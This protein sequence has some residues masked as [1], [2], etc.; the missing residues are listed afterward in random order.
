VDSTGTGA[1]DAATAHL[2][3]TLADDL[4]DLVSRGALRPGDRLPSVR[5]LSKQRRVS[6]STV[7]QA[8]LVLE[9]R[10]LVEARP[11][12]GHYVRAPRRPPPPE[13]RVARQSTSVTRVTVSDLVTRV[14]RAARDPQVVPLGA[15]I[16]SPELYPTDKLHRTLAAVAR[17]A[18]GMG[19]AYD[20][21]P[22]YLP[23]RRH[24]ARRAADAG[25]GLSP[26]DIV[27]TAG[28]M[29]G[30]HLC[31]RSVTRA[32][33]TVIVESPGYY[34]LLQLV[35][36]MELKALEIP[37][38]PRFGMDLGALS[39]AVRRHRVRAVLAVPTFSNPI[40]SLMPDEAKEELVNILA[41]RQIPLIE[42]DIC[43]DLHFEAP[44]PR[45]AKAFDRE[46]LVM[47]C[48]SFSKTLAPGYRVGWVAPGRFRERV[49][50]LK[51]TQTIAAPTVTHMAVAEFLDA[52]GYDH[53]LRHLRRKLAEQVRQFSD[54]IAE[55]FPAGTRVS[56]PQGGLVV[57]VELPPGTS[58]LDLH[59][60]AL[61]QQISIAPGPIFSAKQ[62]FA[63]CI[64]ISCGHPWSDVFARSIRT[65]GRMAKELGTARSAS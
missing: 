43:G 2:Y 61:A 41:R 23:L 53:H 5:Q 54:A 62:R 18:R 24:I 31:L 49:E 25:C 32:G 21:P 6:V 63:S 46:G 29:E 10:G 55:H 30:L 58:A 12:S 64:R 26:D 40:G 39:D 44:R 34:G 48:S 38:H 51:F 33:D 15:A 17:T 56:R 60:R 22:G 1:I 11:Q 35:E 3:E 28:T 13:P 20:M 65:L 7:L 19:I 8:Y 14:Y 4:A 47:L 52:G 16:P 36:S 9:S 42:D 37:T 27:T 57:W 45:P 59:A 50:Q